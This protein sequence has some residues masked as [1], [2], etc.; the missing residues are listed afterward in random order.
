MGVKLVNNRYPFEEGDLPGPLPDIFLV[1]G[2]PQA[3]MEVRRI[4]EEPYSDSLKRVLSQ[5]TLDSLR[6][7]HEQHAEV[8][9]A[10]GRRY[11]WHQDERV[12]NYIG[13]IDRSG[14]EG[15]HLTDIWKFMHAVKGERSI[16]QN[17]LAPVSDTGADAAVR[18]YVRATAAD[19]VPAGFWQA[20]RCHVFRSGRESF[21][22]TNGS[23]GLTPVDRIDGRGV[24]RDFFDGILWDVAS[25]SPFEVNVT[26]G[27]MA[28][29]SESLGLRSG[30]RVLFY[31]PSDPHYPIAMSL[32]GIRG[33]VVSEVMGNF[34]QRGGTAGPSDATNA[35]PQFDILLE[36]FSGRIEAAGGMLMDAAVVAAIRL[37]LNS[38]VIEKA[39]K[40][41]GELETVIGFM[42]A[43]GRILLALRGDERRE[44]EST[45]EAAPVEGG[46]VARVESKAAYA[47]YEVR[48]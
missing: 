32:A 43:G 31:E 26:G 11:R 10:L 13:T 15:A 6:R 28:E 23:K 12:Y 37:P 38:A 29:R 4:R 7:F 16:S 47:V 14:Q 22:I 44:V 36:G 8:P 35:R 39:P 46:S 45:I 2:T 34:R 18:K 25:N 3:E 42:A 40:A 30:M 33:F 19:N 48:G 17:V 9:L 5:K 21:L 27:E 24:L 41:K 20:D 1:E